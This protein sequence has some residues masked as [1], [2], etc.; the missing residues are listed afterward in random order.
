MTSAGL[1]PVQTDRANAATAL[2]SRAIAAVADACV[3]IRQA[4]CKR[5]FHGTRFAS[6][7]TGDSRRGAITWTC[8]CSLK[9]SH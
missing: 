1:L 8:G 2:T 7:H 5:V 6:T 9:G 3:L 4:I